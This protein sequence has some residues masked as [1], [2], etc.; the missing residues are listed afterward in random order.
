ML[1][2]DMKAYSRKFSTR[3][4]N[5]QARSLTGWLSAVWS[6]WLTG[7]EKTENT[8]KLKIKIFMKTKKKYMFWFCCLLL[9]LLRLLFYLSTASLNSF[10]QFGCTYSESERILVI[11]RFCC[12][13][14]LLFIKFFFVLSSWV[15][16]FP[17]HNK[18][19]GYLPGQDLCITTHRNMQTDIRTRCASVVWTAV[20]VE[21]LR[22][23][24]AHSANVW[25]WYR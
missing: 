25:Q 17:L 11:M 12:F 3:A 15:F 23:R 4:T 20:S 19:V 6:D 10:S 9:L 24:R 16:K 5:E 21:L 8:T 7:W 1:I 14:L 18:V 2:A 13:I 22:D